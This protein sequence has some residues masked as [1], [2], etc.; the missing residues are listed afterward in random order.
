MSQG[1]FTL[2]DVIESSK[3]NANGV[4]LY[5]DTNDV[6]DI[7]GQ[8]PVTYIK[9]RYVDNKGKKHKFPKVKFTNVATS[10]GARLTY[11]ADVD[12]T[13]AV[14]INITEMKKCDIEGG[15][16]VAKPKLPHDGKNL[17]DEQKKE[18]DAAIQKAKAKMD[19][20]I[21]GIEDSTRKFVQVLDI[22][23]NSYV[24]E[25]KRLKKD[26]KKLDFKL[27]KD[28]KSKDIPVNVIK[29]SARTEEKSN[30]DEVTI[31]LDTPVYRIK[32]PIFRN[33]PKKRPDLS[34][35]NGLVGKYR[36]SKD[37][38]KD[39]ERFDHIVYDLRK[40]TKKNDYAPV[41]AKVLHKGVPKDL[42]VKNVSA[43]I[44]YKSLITGSLYLADICSSLFG[45]SFNCPI[46]EVYVKRHMTVIKTASHAKE[47]LAKARNGDGSDSEEEDDIDVELEEEGEVE[48]DEEKRKDPKKVK[49]KSS[50]ERNSDDEDDEDDKP[51]E[52]NEA[53]DEGDEELNDDEPVDSDED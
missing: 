37:K 12:K 4:V 2:D 41:L 16:F 32:L 30:G 27:K 13:K 34:K 14:Q 28:R 15:D 47:E 43:F 24:H 31:D 39:K 17:T 35:Y 49:S 36:Y 1:Y 42:D 38:D 10:S 33:D 25:C 29:Q 23:H 53:E 7:K 48:G 9:L 20:K 11:G 6:N 5:A 40:S 50:D 44:T 3:S 46:N 22:L 52:N 45:L 8:K 51:E 26:E 19:K 21:T 18:N